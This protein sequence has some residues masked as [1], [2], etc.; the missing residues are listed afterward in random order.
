M[1]RRA[2]I[3][4]GGVVVALVLG[5]CGSSVPADGLP[6]ETLPPE[7]V[8]AGISLS[9]DPPV[10]VRAGANDLCQFNVYY[11]NGTTDTVEIDATTTVVKD[12]IGTTYS[13][14]TSE[15]AKRLTL[16]TNARKLLLWAFTLPY[17]VK[18]VEIVWVSSD[19]RVAKAIVGDATASASPSEPVSPTA[20]PS[21]SPSESPSPV[22]SPTPSATPTPTPTPSPTASPSK[23]AT[24]K[25][26]PTKTRRPSSTP[27]PD[28]SI[29]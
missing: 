13:G 11:L 9:I 5:A 2:A 17:G 19:G 3:A 28:G 7:Q 22:E 25:P 24:P 20:S 16:D 14:T 4:A 29:G 15:E 10:C 18:P 27:P 26:S 21:E 1:L 8:P 12:S 6:A 23:T